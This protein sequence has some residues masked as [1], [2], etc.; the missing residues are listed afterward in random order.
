M[1]EMELAKLLLALPADR[2]WMPGEGDFARLL[3]DLLDEGTLLIEEQISSDDS[4]GPADW[5]VRLTK[6][7][8]VERARILE[9]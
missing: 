4:D 6:A 9:A 7:G 8:V 5:L 1:A 2:T 3:T